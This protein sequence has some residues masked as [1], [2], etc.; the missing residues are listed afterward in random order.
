MLLAPLGPMSPATSVLMI[1]HSSDTQSTVMAIQ[2][3][4][5]TDNKGSSVHIH[6]LHG[7]SI[8]P[9]LYSVALHL[10]QRCEDNVRGM[11]EVRI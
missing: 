9:T 1:V 7:T 3:P 8:R 4:G 11:R 2:P 10:Y 6:F 5:S